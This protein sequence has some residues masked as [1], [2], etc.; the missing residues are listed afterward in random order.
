MIRDIQDLAVQIVRFVD[1]SFP[2][3]VE[4]Q[5][6]DAAG[7]VHTL[8]DKYPI[9]SRQMLDA[10]SQYPQTGAVE[11]EVLDRSQDARQGEL[12]RIRT[13]G[14]ESAEGLSEFV[15]LPLQ[16]SAPSPNHAKNDA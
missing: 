9:F 4:S 15:V 3:W 10:D 14:I 6:S 5:F 7:H 8:V 2:G 13:L 16:L 11:C 1:D 12:V